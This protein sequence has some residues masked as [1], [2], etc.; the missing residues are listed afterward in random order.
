MDTPKK[1][2]VGKVTEGATSVFG[3]GCMSMVGLLVVTALFFLFYS[4]AKNA[5]YSARLVTGHATIT[6]EITR[7]SITRRDSSSY[8]FEIDGEKYSGTAGREGAGGSVAVAYL[9][10]NPAVNRPLDR[11]WF[12]IGIVALAPIFI[13]IIALYDRFKNSMNAVETEEDIGDDQDELEELKAVKHAEKSQQRKKKVNQEKRGRVL[14]CELPGSEKKKTEDVGSAEITVER[15]AQKNDTEAQF[16]FATDSP[17]APGRIK[18]DTRTA[19]EKR[20]KSQSSQTTTIVVVCVLSVLVLGTIVW[21]LYPSG[22]DDSSSEKSATGQPANKNDA[23]TI[24]NALA[25]AAKNKTGTSGNAEEA[26][27]GYEVEHASEPTENKSAEPN[28]AAGVIEIKGSKFEIIKA[29]FGIGRKWV[30]VTEKIRTILQKD[31]PV[32]TNSARGLSCKDPKSG[33]IKKTI[34][35]YRVNGKNRKVALAAGRN[36]RFNLYSKL[37]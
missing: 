28:V 17:V 10:G 9:K 5:W 30:D 1:S 22:S 27:R 35:E 21:M 12:D 15:T 3:I 34:I 16:D 25:E 4:F 11:L 29:R 18:V 2:I 7:G 24:D 33:Y 26:N 37:K 31:P 36:K 14:N 13:L 6:A 20:N 23:L 32:F 8:A 19:P